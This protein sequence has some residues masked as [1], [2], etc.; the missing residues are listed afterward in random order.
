MGIAMQ[1]LNVALVQ[2]PASTDQSSNAQKGL[3]A[4]QHAAAIGTDIVLF[5]EM[6]NNGYATYDPKKKGDYDAW[7]SKAITS[8]DNF[9]KKFQYA[10]KEL[11]VAIVIT[12]LEAWEDMPRNTASLIDRHG[13]IILT[14]AKVHTC[15]FDVREASITPGTEFFIA[16]LDTKNGN[17]DVGIMICFDRE[18]P[19]SARILMLKGAEII[20]VPNSCALDEQR[21]CQF[22]TRA[23]ENVVGVAMTN[24]PAPQCNG[25]SCAYHADGNLVLHAGKQEGIYHARFNMDEIR[26]LRKEEVWGNAF[27]KPHRYE[28]LLSLDVEKPFKRNNAFGKL[29]RR[30]ER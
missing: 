27:R 17:V 10:A 25:N 12:Y 16:D 3:Q 18:F 7:R 29:F 28:E 21:I 9:V 14:Y 22:K 20:L 11:G 8:D 26:K 23:F 4:C 2:L 6:W 5:P 24:Y 30:K 13:N 15:D 19:E 1:M